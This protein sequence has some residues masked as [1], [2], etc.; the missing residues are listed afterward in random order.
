M[1]CV[2]CGAQ[3]GLD[4]EKCPFCGTVNN[5]AVV[6]KEGIEI[7]KAE[8][9]KLE[10]AVLEA[11][12]K[13]M[14]YKLHKRINII[15]VAVMVLFCV[16]ALIISQIEYDYVAPEDKKMVYELYEKQDLE[17]L[18][19]LMHEK[20]IFG[21][22]GFYDYSYM[23]LLWNNYQ[24]C[25]RW[26]AKAYDNY[27]ANGK[28]DSYYLERCIETGCEILTGYISST[29]G[30]NLSEKNKEYLRPYQE[31]V[32][33]LFTGTFGIPE[34]MLEGL[35]HDDYDREDAIIEYV[36]EVLPNED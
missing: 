14:Y 36:L 24:E 15:L 12:K 1:K 5:I 31:K 23:A 9:E 18:Y 35:E 25:Q 17:G 2:N 8:N 29:Y 34:E 26:Y 10:E 22:E 21:K 4:V 27:L 33:I 16:A 11:S 3:I 13:E 28:Y 7:L 6:R 20:D 32:M 19:N 30:K